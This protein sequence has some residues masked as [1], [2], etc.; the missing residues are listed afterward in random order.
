MEE[1]ELGKGEWRGRGE[2]EREGEGLTTVMR[3]FPK[4]GG[5]HMDDILK[6]APNNMKFI[7]L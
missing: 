3:R 1:G 2:E 4:A 5:S 7:L 6:A